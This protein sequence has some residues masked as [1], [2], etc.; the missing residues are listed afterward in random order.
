[1]NHIKNKRYNHY[2][3]P[4]SRVTL[5]NHFYFMKGSTHIPLIPE[6]RRM[7]TE[8]RH[9]SNPNTLSAPVCEDFLESLPFSVSR[10]H[11]CTFLR[12]AMEQNGPKALILSGGIVQ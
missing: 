2:K 5:L 12:R 9:V 6:L 11:S 7:P 4:F 8:E 1:M 10:P 3:A